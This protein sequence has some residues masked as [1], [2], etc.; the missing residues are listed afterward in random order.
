MTWFKP[1]ARNLLQAVHFLHTNNFAHQDIHVGNIFIAFTKDELLPS[2]KN[3]AINFKLGDFGIAKFFHEISAENTLAGWM[4]P[5]EIL[6]PYE[7]GTADHRIDI[8]HIGL[9]FLQLALSSRLVFTYEEILIGEPRKIAESLKTA[10]GDLIAKMLR[11]H[12]EHRAASVLEV[13]NELKII[14][15]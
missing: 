2:E 14:E 10:H 4:L 7:F 8:Y 12:V 11:R 15:L 6:D 1:I 3:E 13:W 5:P 9:L